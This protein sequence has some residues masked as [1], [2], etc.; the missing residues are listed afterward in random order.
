MANDDTLKYAKEL[1]GYTDEELEIWKSSP[2]NIKALENFDNFSKYKM[3]AEVTHSS[4][5][6]VGHKVG[7]RIVINGDGTLPCKGN[8]EKICFGL[9]GPL[10]THVNVLFDKLN[11]TEAPTRLTFD[12]VHCADVGVDKGG[13]G[14]VVAK[15]TIEKVQD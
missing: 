5:C 7:D 12:K 6:A 3:V 8:P 11:S 1:L 10:A 13:W 9:L 14:A 4:N 15:L 2:N